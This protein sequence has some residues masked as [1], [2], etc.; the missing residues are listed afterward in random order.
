MALLVR[1]FQ[2]Y[3]FCCG[4][5]R[6]GPPC[7]TCAARFADGATG[8]RRGE[9]P[10]PKHSGE[11]GERSELHP[12]PPNGGPTASTRAIPGEDAFCIPLPVIFAQQAV[13][14]DDELMINATGHER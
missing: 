6:A 13:G 14:T 4:V 7:R 10:V 9:N 12:H 5:D 1:R 3:T 8:A 2:P 11:R